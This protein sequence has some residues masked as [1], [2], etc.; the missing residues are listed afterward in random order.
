M[1]NRSLLGASGVSFLPHPSGERSPHPDPR[2]LW[3]LL[4][5]LAHTQQSQDLCCKLEVASAWGSAEVTQ[6]DN[7][8]HRGNRWSDVQRV[9]TEMQVMFQNRTHYPKAEEGASLGQKQFL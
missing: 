6:R 4:I 9:V 5:C 7:P 3:C 2:Y 8:A 1:A